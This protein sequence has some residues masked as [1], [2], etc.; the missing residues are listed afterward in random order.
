MQH[1]RA[2]KDLSCW[3]LI[4]GAACERVGLYLYLLPQT[5]QARKV[6]WNGMDGSGKRFLDYIPEQLIERV[7]N[8]D[9]SLRL[10]NGSILQLTGSNNYNALMGS[11]PVGIV[12]SEYALQDPRA[13]QYLSPI[14]AE[15]GGWEIINTTPRGKN[16]AYN[17]YQQ[18]L[19]SPADWFVQ[20]LTVE[21]T[22]K[23]DGAPVITQE[24]IETERRGG[25]ADELIR[26][27]F[28]CSFDVGIVGSYYTMEMDCAETQGRVCLFD[29]NKNLPVYT[30][31]DL[32]I[33]DA[34]SIWWFQPDGAHINVLYYYENN[35]FGIEHYIQKINDVRDMFKFRYADHFAP[36][37]ISKRDLMTP[38]TRQV[39]AAAKGI[40][41]NRVPQTSDVDKDIQCVKTMFPKFRFHLEHCKVGLDCLREYRRKYDE[42][43]K[44]FMQKPL[45]NWASNCADSFRTFCMAWNDL[46]TK[47]K[48]MNA[49]FKYQMPTP[50]RGINQQPRMNTL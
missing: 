28:Y 21:D 37:D 23:E 18:A 12:Y 1:R 2:G 4:I 47:P 38:Q 10:K 45:H 3:N 36:H 5:N 26:Q 19:A 16:H 30:S 7:N 39:I 6:I 15:N 11:N 17:V 48:H 44:V 42:V 27:E 24:D 13:R 43:N 9:M 32:G 40:H 8:Q 46:Y 50:N 35:N 14:L 41:F 29:I 49:P 20:R 33:S 31:W 34:T 25:M 22:K